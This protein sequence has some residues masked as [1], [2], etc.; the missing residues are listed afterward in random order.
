LAERKG[1]NTYARENKYAIAK[2]HSDEKNRW[3]GTKDDPVWPDI[4]VYDPNVKGEPAKRIAEVETDDTVTIDHA[5]GHWDEYVSRVSDF[6]LAV[7]KPSAKDAKKI[8]DELK[9]GCKLWLYEVT[10]DSNG[11]PTEIE[12]S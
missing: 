7:P 3:V 4:I 12:F 10:L 9:I 2:N 11:K 5:K 1:F 8:L 6:I